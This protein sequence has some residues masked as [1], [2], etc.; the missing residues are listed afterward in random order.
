MI[1][2]VNGQNSIGTFPSFSVNPKPVSYYYFSPR[3]NTRTLN[4]A[5]NFV[6]GPVNL[7]IRAADI[8]GNDTSLG[9]T[10]ET[11]VKMTIYNTAA[12]A[13]SNVCTDN[14]IAGCS[15]DKKVFSCGSPTAVNCLDYSV[16]MTT[17]VGSVPAIQFDTPGIYY[18]AATGPGADATVGSGD[19]IKT[20]DAGDISKM[21]NRGAQ[22]YIACTKDCIK[23]FQLSTMPWT[24]TIGIPFNL[25]VKMVDG[26]GRQITDTSLN[27]TMANETLVWN[28]AVL[29]RINGSAPDN[30]AAIGFGNGNGRI[31]LAFAGGAASIPNMTI[32]QPNDSSKNGAFT[33]AIFKLSMLTDSTKTSVMANNLEIAATAAYE[34]RIAVAG[35]PTSLNAAPTATFNTTINSIDR[36][37]NFVNNPSSVTVIP[38]KNSGPAALTGNFEGTSST[39]TLV[40]GVC[41]INGLYYRVPN[42]VTLKIQSSPLAPGSYPTISFNLVPGTITSYDLAMPATINAYRANLS[43][44]AGTL[45]TTATLKAK[46][47]AGNEIASYGNNQQDNLDTTLNTYTITSANNQPGWPDTVF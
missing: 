10:T 40:N 37:G 47:G 14:D 24:Q 32:N 26:K 23:E 41:S 42:N 45:K 3:T 36:G 35:N 12:N 20:F 16:N 6:E 30:R 15:T 4:N 44:P 8:Y 33:S 1:V 11:A 31:V 43:P 21:N 18:L 28:P 34:Y 13:E 7:S 25:A 9:L 22:L 29:T 39:C 27:S 46:D 5:L 17:G 2:D 38:V 19:D